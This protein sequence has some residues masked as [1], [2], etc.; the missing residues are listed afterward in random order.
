MKN[1]PARTAFRRIASVAISI[2]LLI[3]T[4]ISAAAQEIVSLPSI[5]TERPALPPQP[6][7]GTEKVATIYG[8]KIHYKEAGTGPVVI[9]LHGLG[10]DMS[11]WAPTVDAL[12]KHYRVIVPDQIGF[13]RSDK[14]FINY[15]VATLV[16]FLNGLYKELK[17]ERASLVGNSLGG[18]TAT[19]FALTHPEKVERLVLVDAAGYGVPKE[20]DPRAFDAL[21]PSTR[22][23]VRQ[24]LSLIFYNKELYTSDA[25]VDMFF[26][27]KMAAGDGYTIQRFIESILR[28]EDVL[29]GRLSAIKQPTLIV[30]GREDL[31]TPLASGERFKKDIPGSELVI[32]EKCG[33]VPQLEQA[34][35]FNSIVLNFLNGSSAAGK[36]ETQGRKGE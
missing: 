5:F 22:A 11:N 21:N 19:L 10:G 3:P 33:H 4:S 8:A 31:L 20:T 14:P 36:R 7:A 27:R 17:I 35:Q 28:G 25:A 29:D 24:I 30:W 32:I 2:L 15:R 16:D 12:A 34:A 9:L 18:F 26:A 13:G 6:S 23:A 1:F